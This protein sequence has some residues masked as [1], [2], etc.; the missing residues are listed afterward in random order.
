V[1]RLLVFSVLYAVKLVSRLFYRHDLRWLGDPPADKWRN[2]RLVAFLNHTSLFEPVFLGGVPTSFLWDVAKRGVVPAAD[3]TIDRPLVG[4]FYRFVARDVVP[5]SRRR[6][7]TWTGMLGRV[8]ENSMVLM[9]PEGRMM[10]PTGLDKHGRPMT[11]RGGI[12]DILEAMGEGRM[13]V[14]SSGGLHHVQVPGGWPKVF[15][16]VKA[17]LE[18]L[19]I[20]AYR[21]RLLETFGESGFRDAVKADLERRR[22]ENRPE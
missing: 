6:D 2:V 4:L 9:A 19:D 12:A 5:I 8:G 1:K 14:A 17:T 3:K 20:G 18:L 11:V 15:K 13:L 10:R 22:D 7:E 16:T 21:R